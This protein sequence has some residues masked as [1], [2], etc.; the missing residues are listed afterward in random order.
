MTTADVANVAYQLSQLLFDAPMSVASAVGLALTNTS[1]RCT[2]PLICVTRSVDPPE[3][4]VKELP[5]ELLNPGPICFSI[6]STS[7]PA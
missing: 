5:V 2:L 1:P 4:P 3:K 7:D 6:R